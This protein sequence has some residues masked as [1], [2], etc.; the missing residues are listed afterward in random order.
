[1]LNLRVFI[2]WKTKMIFGIAWH[3]LRI[4]KFKEV[5]MKPVESFENFRLQG[6]PFTVTVKGIWLETSCNHVG[7]VQFCFDIVPRTAQCN[8]RNFADT[9]DLYYDNPW[10]NL[11]CMVETWQSS[12]IFGNFRKMFLTFVWPSENYWRIFRNLDR[13]FGQ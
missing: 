4:L 13:T 11:L 6:N 12:V 8:A 7:I 2:Y 3:F 9:S 10:W 5:L 1:M